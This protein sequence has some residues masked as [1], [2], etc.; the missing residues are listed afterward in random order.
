MLGDTPDPYFGGNNFGLL[1]AC[2]RQLKQFSCFFSNNFCWDKKKQFWE[3]RSRYVRIEDRVPRMDWTCLV[4]NLFFWGTG[5][6]CWPIRIHP[7]IWHLSLGWWTGPVLYKHT[8]V[9]SDA[10]FTYYTIIQYNK[11]LN[12]YIYIIRIICIMHFTRHV[13]CNE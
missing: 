1:H 8:E 2:T 5:T 12:V 10:I 6:Q 4:L 11:Y 7:L 9:R 13:S 3:T